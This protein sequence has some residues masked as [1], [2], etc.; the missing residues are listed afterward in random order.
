MNNSH[1]ADDHDD[2]DDPSSKLLSPSPSSRASSDI[3]ADHAVKSSSST[4]VQAESPPPRRFV[5]FQ[6]DEPA[7][8]PGLP[9]STTQADQDARW[10]F[11]EDFLNSSDDEDFM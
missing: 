4:P 8:S 3:A 9:T 10:T 7:D 5:R 2:L 1:P 11:D 6:I